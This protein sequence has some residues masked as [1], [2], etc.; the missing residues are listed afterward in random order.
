MGVRSCNLS[1]DPQQGHDFVIAVTQ[2]SINAALQQ[3]L[4]RL[5]APV[6]TMYFIHG[7]NNE[8]VPIDY[9]ELTH[10]MNVPDLFAIPD[11]TNIT[12]DPVNK[13]WNAGFA[14][15]I[16][17]KL[18]L[19]DVSTDKLPPI[20]TLGSGAQAPAHFNL[21]CAEFN[22]VGF[23]IDHQGGMG[24][25]VWINKAQPTGDNVPWYFS[26]D[27][28]LNAADVARG[29]I[30]PTDVAT[31]LEKPLDPDHAFGIQDL[32]MQLD[33]A[34]LKSAPEIKGIEPGCP[35][36]TLVHSMFL[37]TY[38]S[39]LKTYGGSV[40]SYRLDT[41]TPAPSTYKPVAILQKCQ[42]YLLSTGNPTQSQKDA[43]TLLYI[44]SLT[45]DPKAVP[46]PFNWVDEDQIERIS[47]VQVV[48][49]DVFLDFLEVQ[50]NTAMKDTLSIASQVEMTH[51]D[52]NFT[53]TYNMNVVQDHPNFDT[54]FRFNLP[55]RPDGEGFADVLYT[56]YETK[57]S[58]AS[59]NSSHA[60]TINGDYTL[61]IEITIALKDN[62]IRI[63]V[64]AT[65]YI[66]FDHREIF[67]NY[68]DLEGKQWYDKT[69]TT[70]YTLVMENDGRVL[71]GR[72]GPAVESKSNTPEWR[73]QGLLPTMMG[74]FG[75]GLNDLIRMNE[76]RLD[77]SLQR[78]AIRLQEVMN[79]PSGWRFPGSDAFVFNHV[80]FTDSH[81][82]F[83]E[84]S[85]V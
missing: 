69:Q 60:V 18:G 1:A 44:G 11:N 61:C 22:I 46:L 34:I 33:T 20:I 79:G 70:Y 52:E 28:L 24:R 54:I 15:A 71:V 12:T 81:D 75:T 72:D 48:R 21:L 40:L 2:R 27:I 58:D 49:K 8:P 53:I 85:Y 65:I 10:R 84:M 64:H 50:A 66:E 36:W 47:G 83:A 14:G 5:D 42:P 73:T 55:N 57:S 38:F 78:F 3:L 16:R 76:E 6:V 82:L 9:E 74:D 77:S 56:R 63:R 51:S 67:A 13:L 41:A 17:A 68:T 39:Q 26:S 31:C 25:P 32:F 43:S 59:T 29:S 35:V 37:K 62:Q 23:G 7:F 80:G 4:G 45:N 30:S 19:P